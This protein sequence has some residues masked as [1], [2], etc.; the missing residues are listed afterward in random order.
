ML[1][2]ISVLWLD[3]SVNVFAFSFILCCIG[4]GLLAFIIRNYMQKGILGV[5]C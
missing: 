3:S 1:V 5:C 4:I 2:V